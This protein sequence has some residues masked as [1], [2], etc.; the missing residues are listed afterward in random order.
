VIETKGHAMK[1]RV[2]IGF[3]FFVICVL[4][5]GRVLVQA[6]RRPFRPQLRPTRPTPRP[7]FAR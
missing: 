5:L 6:A 2:F 1:L 7:A 3:V 4:A